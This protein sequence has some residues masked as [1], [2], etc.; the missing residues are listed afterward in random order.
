MKILA[1]EWE[2]APID[3]LR[4]HPRNPR[5][6]DVAAIR[7]SLDAHGFFGALVAQ[8]STGYIL[9]GNHRFRAACQRGAERLPVLWVDCDDDAALR[10]LLA[11]NRTSDLAEYDRAALAEILRALQETDAGLAGA[12]YRDA[13]LAELEAELAKELAGWDARRELAGDQ[14]NELRAAFEILV[15]CESD[16]QQQDLLARFAA[17][18]LKCRALLS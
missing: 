17:E 10:I 6:G 16:A 3:K 5:A 9:A 18:G 8:R 11:D 12:G 2:L 7:E 4:P 1:Q 13:D 14:T 15:M